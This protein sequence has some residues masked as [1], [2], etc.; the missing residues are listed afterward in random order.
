M[1]QISSAADD[2]FA[3]G[4]FNLDSFGHAS[5]FDQPLD[6]DGG[7]FLASEFEAL[8]KDSAAFGSF[9]YS[10]PQLAGQ[11]PYLSAFMSSLHSSTYT[12]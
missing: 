2:T 3:L 5:A 7:A 9:E 11:D 8:A 4:D 6:M 1:S 10:K 12:I